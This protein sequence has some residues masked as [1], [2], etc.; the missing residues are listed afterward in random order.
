MVG[1]IS[2]KTAYILAPE[3]EMM[4]QVELSPGASIRAGRFSAD[5]AL[6]SLSSPEKKVSKQ[7]LQTM[8]TAVAK[9]MAYE[10][11]ITDA[12]SV[13]KITTVIMDELSRGT[14]PAKIGKIVYK[15]FPKVSKT[16]AAA[17]VQT[18]PQPMATA[19]TPAPTAQRPVFPQ[20]R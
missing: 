6:G 14:P 16:P 8:A 15:M 9:E 11:G 2:V 20:P 17:P 1:S 10:R 18:A 3:A 19:A 13:A 7:K 5:T 12:E 4:P